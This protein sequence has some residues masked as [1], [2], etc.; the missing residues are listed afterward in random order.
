[1]GDRIEDLR[2]WDARIY[3]R[4]QEY[5]LDCFP[6]EFELC[7]H[8]DMIGYMAYSGMPSHYPHWSYGKGFERTKT[9]YDH[10]VSG[11]PYEMVINSNPALAYLMADNSFCLKILTIAHVY[12]HND[13]FKNNFTFGE[14][15]P[16]YTISRFKTHADRVR[17]YVE[18]PSIGAA[19]VEYVLDAAHALA[20]QCRRNLSVRKIPRDE[21]VGRKFEESLPR[22]D[23]HGSIHKKPEHTPPDLHRV[24]LEPEEDILLFIRDTNPYLEDWA[25]DL[26]TIVHEATQ[27]FIPQIETKI[28]NEGWASY[29][30]YNIMSNLDTPED[31]RIEFIVHHNQ[32]LRPHPGGLNPYHIGFR[33]WKSI[34]ESIE[35]DEPPDHRRK[36]A[37]RDALYATREIDRDSS[38]IRRFLTKDLARE[39][40]LFEFK[41]RRGEYVVSEVADEEGWEAIRSTLI[42]S[43]G[44]GS[45]PVIRVSDADHEGDRSLL[46]E[47]EFDGREL[48]LEQAEK[49][50]MYC[51]RLWGRR[52]VLGTVLAGK[53][54][55][56]AYG[57]DGFTTKRQS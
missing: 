37:G 20:F 42:R 15:S 51:H 16:E 38:F 57:E 4:V 8:N 13:F 9:M 43:V 1:M 24:P 6:Q 53:S 33:I 44:T 21:M 17:D 18:D 47:H 36:T 35:G 50:L 31:M 56:L 23:P 10:G 25:R 3:E 39:L 45:I 5:G 26:M 55:E 54:T 12:G 19:K 32:V 30:H 49:A 14:T 41:A 7:D 27:Y 34:Y 22:R 28:M 52:V 48:S 29:W 46:L 40:G 2:D 11:L